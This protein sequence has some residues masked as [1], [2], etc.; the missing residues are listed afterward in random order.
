MLQFFTL[1]PVMRKWAEV[2]VYLQYVMA[3]MIF[4][5]HNLFTV[6]VFIEDLDTK[7]ALVLSFGI[8]NTIFHIY[9]LINDRVLLTKYINDLQAV[10]GNSS[11][12]DVTSSTGSDRAKFTEHCRKVIPRVKVVR[13]VCSLCSGFCILQ[14][15]PFLFGGV[16]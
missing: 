11:I 2:T 3:V 16:W 4:L 6:T 10:I 15:L 1:E 5:S 8:M 9:A 12:T 7:Y 14:S 13:L